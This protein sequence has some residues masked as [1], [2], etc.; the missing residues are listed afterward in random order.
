MFLGLALWKLYLGKS[1]MTLPQA[2]NRD[3]RKMPKWA[4]HQLK[5]FQASE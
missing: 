3:I 5:G 1:Q 2:E 4:H